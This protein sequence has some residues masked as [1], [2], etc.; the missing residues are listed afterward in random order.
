MTGKMLLHPPAHTWLG[1][2]LGRINGMV[3]FRSDK[4]MNKYDAL[5]QNTFLLFSQKLRE[6]RE[7]L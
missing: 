3:S 4:E 5:D 6:I 1:P 2:V 7:N